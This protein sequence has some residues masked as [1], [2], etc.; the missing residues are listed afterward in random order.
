VLASI[1][2]DS[3]GAADRYITIDASG[4]S[5]GTGNAIMLRD[6]VEKVFRTHNLKTNVN[7]CITGTYEG[8]LSDKQLDGICKKIL[9]D[10]NATKVSSNRDEDIISVSAFSP[11]I[12]DKFSIKGK[13]IN[14]SLAIRYNKLENKTYIW[15]ATPVV[16]TEY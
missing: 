8:N 9:K 1:I 13:Q 4:D 7:S 12:K 14:L 11:L 10:S 6:K 5:N 16:N 3:V 2:K 15:V